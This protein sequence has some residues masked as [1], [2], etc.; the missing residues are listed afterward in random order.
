MT[1]LMMSAAKVGAEKENMAGLSSHSVS[2][3]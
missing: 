2:A 3:K 1:E